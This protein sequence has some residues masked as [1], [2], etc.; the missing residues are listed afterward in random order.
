M[1]EFL[2][3]SGYFDLG[4]FAGEEGR[5]DDWYQWTEFDL[6]TNDEWTV[7]DPV[8]EDRMSVIHRPMYGGAEWEA[9]PLPANW[10]LVVVYSGDS[11]SRSEDQEPT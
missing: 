9:D 5:A 4:L 8:G 3:T 2:T 11:G 10:A 6:D 7:L 1:R